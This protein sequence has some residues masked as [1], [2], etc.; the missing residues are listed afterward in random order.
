MACA[1]TGETAWTARGERGGSVCCAVE[2]D[3]GEARAIADDGSA[4]LDSDHIVFGKVIGN[5]RS[6]GLLVSRVGAC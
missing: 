5:A 3:I 2:L 6:F 4:L 1:L